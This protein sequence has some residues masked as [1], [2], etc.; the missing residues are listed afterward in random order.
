MADE[1]RSKGYRVLGMYGPK[2]LRGEYHMIKRNPRAF[3]L[4][5]SLMG[6]YLRTRTRP[7]KAAAIFCVKEF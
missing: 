6:H 7:E 3:W 2:S 1:M 4:L 5:V